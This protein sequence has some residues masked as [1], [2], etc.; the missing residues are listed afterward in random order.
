M[1]LIG[2][3]FAVESQIWDAP[4]PQTIKVE[5]IHQGIWASNFA[6]ASKRCLGD[7]AQCRCKDQETVLNCCVEVL[8]MDGCLEAF[9]N[10]LQHMLHTDNS[11]F[12]LVEACDIWV[13]RLALAI[14]GK[15]PILMKSSW[16]A[17]I[18][19]GYE[20]CKVL[21]QLLGR[22][23]SHILRVG[24]NKIVSMTSYRP[25]GKEIGQCSK[26]QPILHEASVRVSP[27]FA[28]TPQTFDID[29][30]RKRRQRS[31]V[32]KALIFVESN[33]WILVYWCLD[34]REV[35][36]GP[37]RAM[38]LDPEVKCLSII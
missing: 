14:C 8:A 26:E 35:I 15:W 32:I 37:K 34:A 29:P 33:L 5:D 18:L 17:S 11:A 36:H 1:S 13:R 16:L 22:Y 21:V 27:I 25:D 12:G 9:L 10:G 2:T 3:P 19:L 31:T 38:D 6:V 24:G 23:D 28:S 7:A 4:E 20:G 30:A